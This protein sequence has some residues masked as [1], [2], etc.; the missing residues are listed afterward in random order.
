M[1]LIDQKIVGIH[2]KELFEKSYFDICIMDT[3]WNLLNIKP[4]HE[5]RRKLHALHCV[6]YGKMGDE[7]QLLI[8]EMV[9][10]SLEANSISVETNSTGISIH[11]AC[12]DT[13]RKGAETGLAYADT[14][15][16]AKE[17]GGAGRF[18]GR[19]L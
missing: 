18:I 10:H 9:V 1:N 8:M 13:V 2:L 5:I 15:K 3:V 7:L 4:S 11:I 6:N 14:I 12:G 16:R 17:L 19:G